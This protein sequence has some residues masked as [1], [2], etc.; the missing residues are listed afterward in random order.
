[1]QRSHRSTIVVIALLLVWPGPCLVHAQTLGAPVSLGPLASQPPQKDTPPAP[2]PKTQPQAQPPV[3]PKNPPLELVEPPPVPGKQSSGADTQLG[4]LPAPTPEPTDVALPINLATALKLADARPLIIAA[5]Q[6]GAWVAEAQLARAQVLW[7]PQLNLGADYTRHDG[8]GPDFNRGLNTPQR[9][10]NQNVNLLYAG[11]G[12]I[13]DVALSDAIFQPLAARQDLNAK[14]WDIQT[15]KNDALLDTTRA[16]FNVHRARGMYAGSLDVVERGKKLVDT[17]KFLTEELVPKAEFNRAKRLLADL[18]QA[19]A[20][21]REDWRVASA[22]LT[23]VLRLDPRAVIVPIEHDHLQITLID[24]ARPLDDLIPI[25]L[26]NRPELAGQQALVQAAIVR[27]RQEKLRPLTPTLLLNGFQTPQ[28]LL[29]VGVTA[30]GSG[31]VLNQW[32]PRDD[33][34]PQV[35]W[36]IDALGFGNLARIKEQRGNQSKAIVELFKAQDR[37]AADITRAQARLQSAAVRVGQAERSLREALITYDKNYE[38]LRQTQRIGKLLVQAYRPQEV[39]VALESLKMAYDAYFGTVAEYNQAEFELFHALGYPA[40]DLAQL[41]PPGEAMPV[42][43]SRPEY[44]PPVGV[45]PPPST[46]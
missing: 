41:H 22:D 31:G 3:Q 35:L 46:R 33:F 9:P 24:P 14:R 18:E 1:M 37:V 15:A 11:G 45:G 25:G 38:G 4:F 2:S 30:Y 39:V 44:L 16:Y 42:D 13:Q 5:A 6:A 29:Q 21:A 32:S 40:Q 10:L 28:E 27:I 43:L 20:S 19:V 8:Y 23:Q 7:L 34:S 17:V 26:T 12:F 36:Q